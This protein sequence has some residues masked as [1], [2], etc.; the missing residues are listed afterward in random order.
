MLLHQILY[1]LRQLSLAQLRTT[2]TYMVEILKDAIRELGKMKVLAVVT[3]N[4]L[5]MKLERKIL[6][7]E[8]PHISFYG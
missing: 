2:G 7:H 5:N 6:K 4:A 3:D 1:I 8:F